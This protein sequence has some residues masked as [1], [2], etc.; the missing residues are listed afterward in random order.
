SEA[1]F[2]FKVSAQ[3]YISFLDAKKEKLLMELAK[4]EMLA[5]EKRA[6]VREAMQKV[7]VLEKLR[8]K[9]FSTWKRE[10]EK[11]EEN[12]ADDINSSKAA[13]E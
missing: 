1:D 9:K 7:K 12:T 8:E 2:S 5:E 11:E 4:E 3:N 6:V 13:R 10:Y